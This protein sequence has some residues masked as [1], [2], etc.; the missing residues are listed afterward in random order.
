[1][2]R[3]EV[4]C[5]PAPLVPASAGYVDGWSYGAALNKREDAYQQKQIGQPQSRLGGEGR[6]RG[7]VPSSPFFSLVFLFLGYTFKKLP[8]TILSC[9]LV[10]LFV[11]GRY[12]IS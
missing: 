11:F 12:Y 7:Q 3:I 9:I 5:V 1:M 10:T 6:K 4:W 2:V 8:S